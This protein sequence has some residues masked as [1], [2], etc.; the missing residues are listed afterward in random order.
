M[1]KEKEAHYDPD[2]LGKLEDYFAQRDD[3]KIKCPN[4][5]SNNC[6]QE[7]YE[8]D[9][10]TTVSAYMCMNCGYT[11]S[12]HNVEGSAFVEE[13]EKIFPTL[14]VDLR[15]VD[16]KTNL[17]WYPITL[18][19]P[20]KG[21]IFPDGSSAY[22]WQWRAAPIAKIPVEEQ[23]NYPIPG[24]QGEYYETKIDMENSRLYPSLQFYHACRYL[25][26]IVP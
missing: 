10:N 14:F 18:N 7:D 2:K 6:F 12:T 26:I 13:I 21:I 16:S 24:K 23:I 1:G 8:Q 5:N 17:V 11:T 4:C 22:D 25:D 9:Q 15:F 19:F 20:T 3:K